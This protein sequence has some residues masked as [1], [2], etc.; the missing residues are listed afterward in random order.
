MADPSSWRRMFKVGDPRKWARLIFCVLFYMILTGL[1]GT[2]L[3]YAAGIPR[4]ERILFLPG[5]VAAALVGWFYTTDREGN[6]IAEAGN[7]AAALT[8]ARLWVDANSAAPLSGLGYLGYFALW[9]VWGSYVLTVLVI[10]AAG[11]WTEGRR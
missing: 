5:L 8:A 7:L 10:L 2:V 6:R 11:L 3:T 4:P 9:Y 1:A